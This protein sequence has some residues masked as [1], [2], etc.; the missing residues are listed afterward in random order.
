MKPKVLFLCTGNSCRSQMAEGWG[1]SLLRDKC[2]V[3]SAGTEPHPLNQRAVKAMNE[4][5]VDI[6][7]HSSKSVESL[8]SVPFDLIVSV[9]DS[10]AKSCPTPPEGVRIIQAPFD[11]PP[12]LA[13]NSKT[14]NEAMSH[15]RRVR[16]EIK[17]FVLSLPA[18]WSENK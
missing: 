15:Y 10:A 17:E 11:D 14:E 6:S 18:I 4:S 12:Q 3:Y 1:K 8:K 5:G 16:D 2:E 9:C 13:E 7:N